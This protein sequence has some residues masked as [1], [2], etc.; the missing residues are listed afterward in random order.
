MI[1]RVRENASIPGSLGAV[2]I[3]CRVILDVW[4]HTP[5][6][7]NHRAGLTHVLYVAIRKPVN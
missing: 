6:K 5:A 3:Q 4:N 1:E 2:I 7:D